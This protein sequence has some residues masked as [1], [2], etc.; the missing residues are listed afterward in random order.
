MKRLV[1]VMLLLAVIGAL[2]SQWPEDP[3]L[4]LRLTNGTGE[5]VIPKVAYG[6]S[7]DVWVSWFS[8]EA[9]NYN[10]RLQKL[11][12][13]GVPQ[14]APEGLLVSNHTQMSWL[15]DWD[16]KVDSQ[17]NAIVSFLDVRTGNQDIYVYK[18]SPEGQ[19]VWGNDGIAVSNDAM[20]DYTPTLGIT[21]QNNVIVAW[22]TET[23][24]KLQKINSDGSIALTEP[25]IMHEE[26]VSYTWPQIMPQ[27]NDTFILKYAHDTGP[28]YAVTRLV[29]AQKY[30]SAV[31]P[32]WANPTVITDQGGISSWTQVFSTDTDGN[33]GFVICWYE[34]R[35]GDQM[36][37]VYVQHVL[38]D[39]S[40]AFV[41]NG[42][43]PISFSTTQHFYPITTFDPE[44]GNTYLLW[45]E[46]DADQNLRGL[47]V[48]GFDSLGNRLLGQ[49]GIPVIPLGGSSPMPVGAD[50]VNQQIVFLFQAAL[51]GSTVNDEI[52][53]FKLNANGTFVWDNDFVSLNNSAGGSV[54]Q[55]T[56]G[57]FNN[58]LVTVW[59]D[60]RSAT[61]QIYL[62]NLNSDGTIGVIAQPSGISGTV[63]LNGGNG[64]ITNVVIT[65]GDQVISPANDST[66]S[67]LLPAGIYT[68]T[69]VLADYETF[70]DTVIVTEGQMTNLN[71]TLDYII[72]ANDN[73]ANKKVNFVNVY[74]NPFNPSTT[75]SYN[76]TARSHVSI[77]VYNTKGQIVKNLCNEERN[78]GTFQLVWNGKDSNNKKCSSGVYFIR[79]NAGEYNSV[80]KVMLLK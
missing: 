15:T 53:A 21:D 14:F 77:N 49:N 41:A 33:G 5:E 54:H 38:A 64:F 42:I 24:L 4:N 40:L 56:T 66:Y 16:M 17:N 23:D 80:K 7:G 29:Y 69:A 11:N 13:N 59:E 67:V 70:A 71:I 76:L 27:E 75:I 61:T 46:T 37:N 3:A 63:A 25:L 6:P 22:M 58:Q 60:T 12:F 48:Q 10:V 79:M 44:L 26:N 31:N 20:A 47:R 2:F 18:V 62:Q 39:G 74:P 35:D 43:E 32:V 8:S 45:S 72:G 65:I 28:F 57:F 36:R 78:P 73:V 55:E 68:V 19:M 52:K 50:V 1:S 30:D 51:N 9:G 34:D